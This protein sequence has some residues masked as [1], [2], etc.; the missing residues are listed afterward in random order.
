MSKPY[1]FCYCEI[2]S[3]TS[4][5]SIF[6]YWITTCWGTC[7]Y[8]YYCGCYG[9][10]SYYFYWSATCCCGTSS[11]FYFSWSLTYS[12]CGGYYLGWFLFLLRYSWEVCIFE[13]LLMTALHFLQKIGSPMARFYLSFFKKSKLTTMTLVSISSSL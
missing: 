6:Y 4:S 5:I 2:S 8:Y 11:I 9:C 10:C 12:C 13:Y 1:F 3:F 7:Y